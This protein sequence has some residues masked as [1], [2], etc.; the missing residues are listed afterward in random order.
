M[1]NGIL[2]TCNGGTPVS[3]TTSPPPSIWSI[4][5]F[6]P[7][8]DLTANLDAVPV[9]NLNAL[10]GNLGVMHDTAGNLGQ[11]VARGSQER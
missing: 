6:E 10:H 1:S 3:I 8:E 9:R 4:I 11:P 2:C 7:G 5:V